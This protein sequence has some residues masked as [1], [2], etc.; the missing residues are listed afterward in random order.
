M[1][2]KIRGRLA[3]VL[4]IIFIVMAFGAGSVVVTN[5][6]TV[7]YGTVTASTAKVRSQTNTTSDVVGSLASGDSIQILQEVTDDSGQVWYKVNVV[8]GTGYI[9]GDLVEKGETKEVENTTTSS[10]ET[11]TTQTTNTT[12][13]SET[14][15]DLP[16]TDVTT[17]EDT[18]ATVT[19]S[20]ANVRSGAGTA[21]SV[22]E[23]VSSGDTL[24]IK[25]TATGTDA[26]EWYYVELSDG[27]TG[28]IRADLVEI[29]TAN[30]TESSTD[31]STTDSSTDSANTDSS[32]D[33]ASTEASND[34]TESTSSDESGDNVATTS[35]DS[36]YVTKDADGTYYLV[37]KTTDGGVKYNVAGLLS[38][39]EYVQQNG[40]SSVSSMWKVLSIV[41][42]IIVV[43]LVILVVLFFIRLR[44]LL[45]FEDDKN[46]N[47]ND[48][49]TDNYD[50]NYEDSYDKSS[51]DNDNDNYD[52]GNYSDENYDDFENE[53]PK[54]KGLFSKFKKNKNED[55]FVE[56]DYQ[57][58]YAE[59]NYADEGTDEYVPEEEEVAPSKNTGAGKKTRNFVS[60]DEFEFEFLDLD[61][62]D[63]KQGR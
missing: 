35:D 54:K 11:T 5:A 55:D 60:D 32:T 1:K 27:S 50:D 33:S 34:A 16:E 57:D 63:D 37:D 19:T 20:R 6:E 48:G 8:G 40:T 17:M 31:A 10:E 46:D 24:T 15:Q 12:T 38:A 2:K 45:Y 25:G 29:G 28:F 3:L 18:A 23:G 43:I 52:D 30:A 7:T 53:A 22:V 56:D 44:Q 39:N 21:Y 59:D 4:A 26:K 42:A 62:D 47:E 61:S 41:L 9:R 14:T 51:Y 36:Y 58:D 13:T 49:Y